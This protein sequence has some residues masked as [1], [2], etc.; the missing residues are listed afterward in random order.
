MRDYGQDYNKGRGMLDPLQ[1]P[2][3]CG[4]NFVMNMSQFN[5]KLYGPTS[6]SKQL[7]VATRF[8]GDKGF[9]IKFVNERSDKPNHDIP[10]NVTGFDVSWLSRFGS[11]EDERYNFFLLTLCIIII[12]RVY[13]LQTILLLLSPFIYLINHSAIKLFKSTKIHSTIDTFR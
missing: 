9:L 8:S 10:T 4:M 12:H 1:G 11:Q 6:T 13:S 3:Y 5:I 2:Y 7:S